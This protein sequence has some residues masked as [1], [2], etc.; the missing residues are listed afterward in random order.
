VL[1]LSLSYGLYVPNWEFTVPASASSLPSS[2]DSYVYMVR[3]HSV[4]STFPFLL[5]HYSGTWLAILLLSIERCGEL[6]RLNL[7]QESVCV[8]VH[9]YLFSYILFNH[10][11][12]LVNIWC[13]ISHLVIICVQVLVKYLLLEFS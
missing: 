12:Q 9:I 11:N 2:N 6:L 13:F 10:L 7:S 3:A 8:C 1:Y 5:L 4:V